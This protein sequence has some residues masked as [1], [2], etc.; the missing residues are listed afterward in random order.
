MLTIGRGGAV[1]LGSDMLQRIYGTAWQ[2]ED[3]LAAYHFMKE[4]AERRDHRKIGADLNLFSIQVGG[5]T[6]LTPAQPAP[7][8]SLRYSE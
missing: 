7:G 2:T 1:S 5:P 6:H 3:E 8:W 4:E